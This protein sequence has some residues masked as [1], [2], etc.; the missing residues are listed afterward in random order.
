MFNLIELLL[1]LMLIMLVF[2]GKIEGGR[3]II[4]FFVLFIKNFLFLLI[5]ESCL[6]VL[7]ILVKLVF[8][9]V[10]I[11]RLVLERIFN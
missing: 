9:V 1:V 5:G 3:L 7:F 4:K 8:V 6:I 11:R 2:V 10:C